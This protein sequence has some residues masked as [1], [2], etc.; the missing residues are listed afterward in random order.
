MSEIPLSSL[1]PSPTDDDEGD[2]QL[3]PMTAKAHGKQRADSQSEDT[4]SD[5]EGQSEYPPNLDETQ[6]IEEVLH[7]QLPYSIKI[8]IP[9]RL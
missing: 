8:L 6:R 5:E 1:P 4:E 2:A 3:T 7:L 9:Y